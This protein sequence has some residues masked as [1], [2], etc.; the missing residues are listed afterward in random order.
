M[1]VPNTQTPV[2]GSIE[3]ERAERLV[4]AS[5]EERTSAVA[6]L[7][8]KT[9]ITAG[10]SS[11]QPV[12][13][14]DAA[15]LT[16]LQYRM[17]RTIGRIRGCGVDDKEVNR[18]FHAVRKPIIASQAWLLVAK[19]L[20]WIP[21]VP[22][23]FAFSL[24]YSLTF[25]MGKVSDEYFTRKGMSVDELEPRLDEVSKK[26]FAEALDVKRNELRALFRD[27]ETR[28]RIKELAKKQHEG[29]IDDDEAA[30]RMDA[31]LGGGPHSSDRCDGCPQLLP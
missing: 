3:P 4:H 20:Q 14:L 7:I 17:V 16:P 30:R 15:I 28:H 29:K 11:L 27:P 8:H 19:L 26:T 10:V 13:V 1:S 5:E 31:I 6:E 18:M 23:I 21:W 25:A 12:P 9:S 22:E 2:F 24:S